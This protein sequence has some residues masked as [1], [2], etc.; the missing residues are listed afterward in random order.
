MTA[1]IVYKV[2]AANAITS[3]K[4]QAQFS[5][6]A[7]GGHRDHRREPQPRPDVAAR[8]AMSVRQSALSSRP[9][10]TCRDQVSGAYETLVRVQLTADR[11][12]TRR[13]RADR[14]HDR[15]R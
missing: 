5:R 11:I 7:A 8:S 15:A 6:T 9:A 4:I 1:E 14:T 12:H 13:Y 10:P 2:Q 3:Q